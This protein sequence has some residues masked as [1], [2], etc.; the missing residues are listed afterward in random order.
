VAAPWLYARWSAGRN[1]RATL[2]NACVYMLWRRRE[3]RRQA[4]HRR[5]RWEVKGGRERQDFATAAEGEGALETTPR[6]S[7]R[8]ARCYTKTPSAGEMEE[9][10]NGRRGSGNQRDK[11]VPCRV[12]RAATVR[13]RGNQGCLLRCGMRTTQPNAPSSASWSVDP[14]SVESGG[15]RCVY[16]SRRPRWCCC[17]NRDQR[18]IWYLLVQAQRQQFAFCA[19]RAVAHAF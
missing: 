12:E 9:V 14:V 6:N 13:V 2:V 4:N 18:F 1:H 15:K 19:F 3:W 17:G 16:G 5:H 8:R 11:P 7:G 10:S